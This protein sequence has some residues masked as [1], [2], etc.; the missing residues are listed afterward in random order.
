MIAMSFQEVADA[1]S[2]TLIDVPD[3]R[4]QITG[5]AFIDSRDVEP[6]GLFACVVGEKVDGHDFV[7]QAVTR[8]AALV[9]SAR[10]V[11]VPAVVVDDVVVAL[12]QLA[13][14]LLSRLPAL[15]VVAITGS[16]GKTTTKDLIAQVAAAI[17]PTVSPTGSFNT[18]IG[19]PL[20]VLR[21]DE[22]TRVLVL[23]MGAR[24]IGHIKYLCTIAR[25]DI[26]VVLNVG[27][28]HVGQFGSVSAIANAKGELVESLTSEGV[29]ILNADDAHV[30][31]MAARTSASVVLFGS[32]GTADV[33]GTQK[34]MGSGARAAFVLNTPEGS[35]P[36]TLQA[37][38]EHQVSNALAAAAVGRALGLSVAELATALSSAAPRSRWR[39]EVTERADGLLVINDAYNANPESVRA[40]LEALL[41]LAGDRRSWAVLGEMR[42]LGAEH[43][44]QHAAIGGLAA[45]LGV[46]RLVVVGEAA[47]PMLRGAEL[48]GSWEEHPVLVVDVDAAIHHLLRTVP[49]GDVV[50]VKASRSIGLE[51]VAEAL[52]AA[53]PHPTGSDG[54]PTGGD[55]L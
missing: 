21:A 13:A 36:V 34:S 8:G 3:P 12:G 43:D 55:E 16:S 4:A 45:E 31:A 19:L 7:D 11:G 42:E 51:R 27:S 37:V 50:L 38:G 49:P 30:S 44:A 14:H 10:P 53:P 9:L 40:A 2:G 24:G 25:P 23:E 29:A 1:V 54:I 26:G 39:M 41:S 5:Q 6:G 46:D 48:G 33:R 47:R 32:S 18:E 28:A 15:R 20:T 22:G 17:G 52:L 35:A